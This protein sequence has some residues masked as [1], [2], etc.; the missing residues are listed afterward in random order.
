MVTYEP[1]A[2]NFRM[3]VAP[4]KFPLRGIGSL[5]A[6]VQAVLEAGVSPRQTT[7]ILCVGIHSRSPLKDR[8]PWAKIYDF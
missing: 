5:E 8:K 4:Q 7:A 6:L 3:A 1:K 2:P